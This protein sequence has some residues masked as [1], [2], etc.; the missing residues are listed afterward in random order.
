MT[1]PSQQL[2]D[3]MKDVK[4]KGDADLKLDKETRDK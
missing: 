2:T 3:N 1:S 4:D